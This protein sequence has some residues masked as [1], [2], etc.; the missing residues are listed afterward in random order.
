M[1]I[2]YT[3]GIL[4]CLLGSCVLY[5]PTGR[6]QKELKEVQTTLTENHAAAQRVF[7]E[8][9]TY[10]QQLRNPAREEPYLTARSKLEAVRSDMRSLARVVGEVD[11]AYDHFCD[12][13]RGM[14]RIASN[15]PEWKQ[16]KKTRSAFKTNM[17]ELKPLFENFTASAEGYR[18]YMEAQVIPGIKRFPIATYQKAYEQGRA[19]VAA[20]QQQILTMVQYHR[21][22]PDE[23]RLR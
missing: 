3:W 8:C 23:E 15:T 16:L 19:E 18:N 17:K 11:K 5:H 21:N 1:K 6:V 12:Y 20:N 22:I 7:E 9:D 4:G 14:D 10:F 13:S 2:R